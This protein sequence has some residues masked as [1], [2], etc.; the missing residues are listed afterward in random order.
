MEE[1][2]RTT[3]SNSA[4][5]QPVMVSG[6]PSVIQDAVP[7][8]PDGKKTAWYFSSP[9]KR[10][11]ENTVNLQRILSITNVQPARSL[12]RTPSPGPSFSRMRHNHDL[13]LQA[14][15]ICRCADWIGNMP[16]YWDF[17]PPTPI[18]LNGIAVVSVGPG[19]SSE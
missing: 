15:R 8:V 9:F 17:E 5:Q 12:R 10:I 2:V 4:S 16:V 14:R 1:K 7:G 18:S 6:T 19:S 13:I 11:Q 3:I